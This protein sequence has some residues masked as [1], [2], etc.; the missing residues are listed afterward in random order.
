MDTKYD[1]SDVKNIEVYR[2][3]PNKWAKKRRSN[4][5]ITIA[6]L[7][8]SKEEFYGKNRDK[9]TSCG[10][11]EEICFSKHIENPAFC[12]ELF[13]KYGLEHK[14][15]SCN[16]LRFADIENENDLKYMNLIKSGELTIKGYRFGDIANYDYRLWAESALDLW[17]LDI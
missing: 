4:P 14:I 10:E 11:T 3:F 16:S 8:V 5:S 6:M 17:V 12:E 7:D 15:R 9:D 2:N 13:S 1:F